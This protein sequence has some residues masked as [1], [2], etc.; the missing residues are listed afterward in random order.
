MIKIPVSE[1]QKDDIEKIYWT[2]ISKYHLDSLKN[3]IENDDVLKRLIVKNN[4]TLETSLKKYLLNNYD[5][6]AQLKVAIDEMRVRNECLKE[7][8][9]F[10]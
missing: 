1:K 8:T 9:K 3:V 2:W 6:L 7:N 4:E 5:N 10:F